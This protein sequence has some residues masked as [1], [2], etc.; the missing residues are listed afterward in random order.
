MRDRIKNCG[1][2]WLKD[3]PFFT[4]E[5]VKEY[6]KQNE[7]RNLRLFVNTCNKKYNRY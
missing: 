7:K 1:Q 2:S 3:C 4:H 6:L 5:D